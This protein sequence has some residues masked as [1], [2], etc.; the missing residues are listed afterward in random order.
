MTDPILSVVIAVYNSE[1]YIKEALES[2]L[3][4]TF[5]DFEIIIVNDGSTDCT[6]KIIEE[7]MKN[8]DGEYQII[9]NEKNM[10]CPV[11]RNIGNNLAR[12]K[13][14][15]VVDGDDISL[16]HRF[17]KQVEK[18][19]DNPQYSLVSAP[20]F[21]MDKDGVCNG[22]IIQYAKDRKEMLR[23]LLRLYRCYTTHPACVYHREAFYEMGGYDEELIIAHDLDLFIRMVLSDKILVNFHEPLIKYRWHDSLSHKPSDHILS[24]KMRDD[25][26]LRIVEKVNIYVE[27]KRKSGK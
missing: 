27:N 3:N 21:K 14:I 24:F 1:Q 23:H 9:S 25:E 22:E 26:A 19:E 20:A 16:P 8:F 6:L 18:L 11:S 4:Q 17:E 10:N 7:T 2:V 12:G 5:K 13:Y 15:G